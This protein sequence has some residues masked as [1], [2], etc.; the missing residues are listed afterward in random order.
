MARWYHRLVAVVALV[1]LALLPTRSAAD[2]CQPGVITT[3]AGDGWVDENGQGRYFG[4]EGAAAQARLRCP[5]GVAV[6]ADGSLY[7]AEEWRCRILK[8]GPAGIITVIASG[9]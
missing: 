4:D 6:T 3:V 5:Y 2:D 1:G 7:I 9:G 8:V